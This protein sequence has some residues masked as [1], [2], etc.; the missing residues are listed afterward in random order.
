MT[1][2]NLQQSFA[3]R[4]EYFPTLPHPCQ[5]CLCSFGFTL[6]DSNEKL[7][8]V[9]D[10]HCECPYASVRTRLSAARSRNGPCAYWSRLRGSRRGAIS[11]SWRRLCER[12]PARVRHLSRRRS[13]DDGGA[14]RRSHRQSESLLLLP[15]PEL[16]RL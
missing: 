10:R 1:R 4:Y 14:D 8:V 5:L 6:G 3:G 7:F 2:A 16:S 12:L 11:I 13:R 15:R 9:W